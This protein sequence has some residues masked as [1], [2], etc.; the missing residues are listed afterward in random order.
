MSI[1]TGGNIKNGTA[2]MSHSPG[3]LPPQSNQMNFSEMQDMIEV[4]TSNNYALGK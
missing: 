4:K 2:G 3:L 1:I